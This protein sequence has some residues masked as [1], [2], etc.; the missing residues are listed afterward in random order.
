[1]PNISSD[2]YFHPSR[3]KGHTTVT[4]LPY[5]DDVLCDSSDWYC[6]FCIILFPPEGH[7]GTR[8]LCLVGKRGSRY[9]VQLVQLYVAGC[10]ILH[11][12]GVLWFETLMLPHVNMGCFATLYNSCPLAKPGTPALRPSLARRFQ[13]RVRVSH[14]RVWCTQL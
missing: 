1:M 9:F 10:N 8:L 12:L 13:S 4:F 14:I 3:L 6:Y 11:S 2:W 7:C 5:R